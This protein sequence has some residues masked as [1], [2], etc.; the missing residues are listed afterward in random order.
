MEVVSP[1]NISSCRLSGSTD[2]MLKLC[3]NFNTWSIDGN[4]WPGVGVIKRAPAGCLSDC[5]GP[6]PS[7]GGDRLLSGKNPRAVFPSKAPRL[8][9]SRELP[10]AIVQ[11]RVAV[12]PWR[13][14]G[15]QASQLNAVPDQRFR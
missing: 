13:G 2:L 1:S 14:G 9:V 3:R 11:E 15:L 7:T 10:H 8:L 12:H 4:A 6:L 5:A